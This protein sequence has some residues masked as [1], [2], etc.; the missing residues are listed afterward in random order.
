LFLHDRA[1]RT[2]TP[3]HGR[4]KA[5][6]QLLLFRQRQLSYRRFDFG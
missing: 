2:P 4:R 6:Q 1:G 5:M 3:A